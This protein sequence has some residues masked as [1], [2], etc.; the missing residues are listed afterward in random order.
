M[1]FRVEQRE[2]RT[3]ALGKPC[4]QS[5]HCD[6]HSGGLDTNDD[7]NRAWSRGGEVSCLSVMWTSPEV[8]AIDVSG[9]TEDSVSKKNNVSIFSTLFVLA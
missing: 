8:V 4:G 1:Q 5:S 7:E 2:S 9:K 3:Q 6:G